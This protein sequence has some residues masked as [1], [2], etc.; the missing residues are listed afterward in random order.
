MA[1]EQRDN[2]SD[3]CEQAL[4]PRAVVARFARAMEAELCVHDASKG[5]WRAESLYRLLN[6]AHAELQELDEAVMEYR[7]ARAT[8][9]VFGDGEDAED[10]W[11]A[12][13]LLSEAQSA[14]RS[15]AADLAL[16]AMMIADACGALPETV[17]RDGRGRA[18]SPTTDGGRSRGGAR[19]VDCGGSQVVGDGWPCPTCSHE[20]R[21][22][23]ECAR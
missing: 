16:Y 9:R 12:E 14:V 13:R 11:L 19:C 7:A 5:D 18:V 23:G 3:A 6:A 22:D 15:E 2:V 8:H 4:T 21:G 17:R 1:R 20:P 10:T